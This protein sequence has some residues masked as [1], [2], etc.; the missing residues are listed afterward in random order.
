M[1]EALI[2]I[3]N[4]RVIYNQG[5]SN[6]VRA[7]EDIV[8]QIFPQEYVTIFGPSGCGKSTLLYV[9]A[10]L[11]APTYG[12]VIVEQKNLL[13]MTKEEKVQLHQT[14][15]G[16]IFQA[17]HLIPSLSV[18]DNVC[19]PRTFRGENVSDRRASGMVLLRRFGIA[20]QADKFPHQLSGGQKQRVAIARALINDPAII[21]ADEPVGNLDTESAQNVLQILKELNAVD[22]KTV[23]LVTHNME[24]IHYA[25]RVLHMKDGRIMQEEI[26]HEKR[27]DTLVREEISAVPGE[28]ISDEMRMLAK[29]FKGLSPQQ[30]GV[31]LIPFKAKQILSHILSELTEEQHT[32]AENLLKDFLFHNIDGVEL[33][34]RLDLELDNGG[35]GWNK[36]RANS[37]ATRVAAITRHAD[38][39]SADPSTALLPLTDYLKDI[40]DV[41]LDQERL[42]RF[43]SCIK[44]RI[45]NKLD[46]FGFQQRLDA[47][48]VL[49]GV[50]LYKTTAEKITREVEIVM[51]LKYS[52]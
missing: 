2:A 6:E 21:L 35:A 14:G 8:L 48:R 50:G 31:L 1:K 33:Q 9:I 12:D 38:A 7:L 13:T 51:L 17:F 27:P 23:I 24:H 47:A 15:V 41:Q 30:I 46:R 18:I 42:L 52:T 5:R 32:A 45:E 16:M 4:L 26:H 49:G 43:R 10:G 29:T 39:I 40:F 28:K 25:D 19:L 37:F 11:Q 36:K 34:R 44:L 20:E 3:K 22:K